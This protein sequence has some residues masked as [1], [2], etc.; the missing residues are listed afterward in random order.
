MSEKKLLQSLTD[1][2]GRLVTKA[3]MLISMIQF[4]LHYYAQRQKVLSFH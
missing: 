4:L 3:R 1:R 2:Q